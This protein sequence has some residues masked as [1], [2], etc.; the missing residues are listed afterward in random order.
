VTTDNVR[1]STAPSVWQIA[2]LT[3]AGVVRLTRLS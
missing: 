2:K 1:P 3:K